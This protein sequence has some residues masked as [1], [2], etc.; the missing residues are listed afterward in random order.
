MR[1]SLL[2]FSRTILRAL[3]SCPSTIAFISPSTSCAVFS[4][5]CSSR[6]ISL[7][8]N[9]WSW[10]SPRAIGPIS[11][12]PQSQ[13]IL[14][15][16]FVAC[17]MSPAAPFVMSVKTASSATLPPR[18]VQ[19]WFNRDFFDSVRMSRDGTNIVDPRLCPRGIIVTLCTGSRPSS[20]TACMSACPA[21]W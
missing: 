2:R 15:A 13:T 17:L 16:I 18:L 7:P 1:S 12:M 4:L 21:S 5:K 3:S 11:P 19:M 9:M 8:K 14:R 6:A 20:M 10:F